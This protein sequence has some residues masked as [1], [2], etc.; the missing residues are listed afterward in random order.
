MSPD[1]AGRFIEERLLITREDISRAKAWIVALESGDSD[2][3]ATQWLKKQNLEVPRD[4]DT[5]SAQVADQLINVARAYSLRLAFYQAVF[6]LSSSG[7]LAIVGVGQWS[8][9]L[10]YSTRRGA[11]GIGFQKKTYVAPSRFERLAV[12]AGIASDP[13]IFLSG[14]DSKQLHPGIR[15]AVEQAIQCFRRGLYMPATAMLAAAVEATWTECG[16]AVAKNLSDAKLE[17]LF[18]DQ[19][20]SI[21]KKVSE[22]RKSLE[23]ATAKPLLKNA[24]QSIAKVNDAEVW[25]TVLR[26][27]RN[28]LHW[29]KAK[30]FIAHHSDTATLL[31]AA[32]LHIGTLEAIRL[33]C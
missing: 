10:C 32:P 6:E 4:V 8:P 7:D 16:I 23:Q 21:S 9:S 25:T 13:D 15:E 31:M 28:A 24:G 3:M 27:R 20:A 30:N 18:S 17:G 29:T 11:G 12:T 2:Q 5:D 1:D 22:L 26:D 19:Y 33:N 14:V